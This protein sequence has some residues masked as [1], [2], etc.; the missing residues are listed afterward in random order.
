MPTPE[1][2][3]S[4]TAFRRAELALANAARLEPAASLRSLFTPET[5]APRQ[6]FT[7]A[8]EY[9]LDQKGFMGRLLGIV[10][11]PLVLFGLIMTIPYPIRGVR[12]L[13]K[14][15]PK[16][17]GL[18]RRPGLIRG[19]YIGNID[20][21]FA[22]SPVP[23]AFKA[24]IRETDS[25][26]RELSEGIGKAVVKYEEATGRAWTPKT[27]R[28]LALSLE[29]IP[30][31][32][33]GAAFTRMVS[34][35]RAVEQTA[36]DKVFVQAQR[37]VE[38]QAASEAGL[39]LETVRRLEKVPFKQLA[40]DAQAALR[41]YRGVRRR[42]INDIVRQ[43]ES[44]GFF[45]TREM[46]TARRIENYY[47]HRVPRKERMSPEDWD[48][49][50]TAG[51]GEK[52]FGERMVGEAAR[53]RT[54]HAKPRHDQ[55]V[56]DPEALKS[57]RGYLA[58]PSMVER[59]EAALAADPT[60]R[61]Y[62]L[63]FGDVMSSYINSVSRARAWVTL[64]HGQ[65]IVNFAK[66]LEAST[67]MGP[68]M[69]HNKSRVALLRDALIPMA[70]GQTPYRQGVLAAEYQSMK[71]HLAKSLKDSNVIRR[72]LGP[73]M[74]KWIED[75]IASDKG[76]LGLRDIQ[77]Y[78]ARLIYTGALGLP[79]VAS[80]VWNVMQSVLTTMPLIG[81]GAVARGFATTAKGI[82]RYAA[83]RL[84]NVT[85]ETAMMRAFPEFVEQGL[86][87]SPTAT[88]LTLGQSIAGDLSEA[89]SRVSGRG[90]ATV[91]GRV[92]Q[93]INNALMSAFTTTE[94]FNR[95]LAF[96][97]TYR[98]AIREGAKAVEAG[99][100]ARNVVEQTQFLSGLIAKPAF[101]LRN[102]QLGPLMQ[103]FG[104]FG[105]RY[106]D[107]LM[108]STEFAS[109]AQGGMFGRNYGT[110]GRMLLYGGLT[111]ETG[112]LL[113]LN[114]SGGLV[115]GAIP[116]TLP[117]SPFFP[118]P[119]VPP[120]LTIAGGAAQAALT[121]NVSTLQRSLPILVPGGIGL[122]RMLPLTVGLI[123]PELGPGVSQL[124]GRNFVAWDQPREDGRV[125]VYSPD[126]QLVGYQHPA[127]IYVS[128]WGGDVFAET[129]SSFER[130][131]TAY[132]TAQADQ[133]AG[134][135]R[136]YLNALYFENDVR[137]AQRINEEYNERYGLGDI[138]VSDRHLD[139]V[140]MRYTVTRLER[141]L[142][143]IPAEVRPVFAALVS[144]AV[145]ARAPSLLGIDP[146]LLTLPQATPSR[147]DAYREPPP[148]D[149]TDYLRRRRDRQLGWAP[150]ARQL[151]SLPSTTRRSS[152]GAGTALLAPTA[153]MP[154]FQSRLRL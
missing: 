13:F 134:Y 86:K 97:G 66:E 95:L 151:R 80:S 28:L 111:Y 53:V 44:E 87:A 47:P 42:T 73:E 57:V 129:A 6:R 25:L 55:M 7:L 74:T 12:N 50:L 81:P 41:Q 113:G 96:Y 146:G 88:E 122:S 3:L 18:A 114:L 21:I 83:D 19:R 118:A 68:A 72:T 52:A 131:L 135:R 99:T 48:L 33:S 92:G 93:D 148:V 84:R 79:N 78:T 143:Q 1:Q 24:V 17:V 125:P 124:T 149:V 89:W 138:Q 112:Q 103:Q 59:V 5:L 145:M 100:L 108:R 34:E 75:G 104:T 16:F 116:M 85:H 63:E 40:P 51:G 15:A 43:L 120:A 32:P 91:A 110:L 31:R 62:S 141:V 153:P 102:P 64:G 77:G 38:K 152:M 121:G 82:G 36:W 49:M 8:E 67:A 139:A 133:I 147:L 35:V 10:E 128:M 69:A 144:Q 23:E 136:N 150:G 58:D 65:K 60:L 115:T 27:G 70:L 2:F 127:E 29:G 4:D 98:T 14:F 71:V 20:S 154:G 107:F 22:G 130:Q 94:S 140:R 137:K 37:N 117:G 56:P 101:F 123:A 54:V 109:G 39:S 9:G 142:N 106:A 61:K 132:I 30:V 45:G 46:L 105:A 119:F 76:I 90:A 126:M 11:N 26:K